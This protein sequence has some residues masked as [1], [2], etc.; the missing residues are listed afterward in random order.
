MKRASIVTM[1]MAA[2][3]TAGEAA[4]APKPGAAAKPP[5][6]RTGNALATQR[7]AKAAISGPQRW[8]LK[9]TENF[10]GAALNK[11]L[12]K[13]I[14]GTPDSGADWQRNISPRED[15]ATVKRGILTL[16]GIKNE[17]QASDPRRMLAGGIST[18]GLF[19]MKYGKIEARVR[20]KGCKGAWPAFWMMPERP[21]RTWPDCGEIDIFERLNRD[22]FVLQ[23]VH[24]GWAEAH[25]NDPPR[26]GK[27]AIKT[28]DWNV[29]A[30]EWTPEK[31]VWLVNG[32]ATHSYPKKA[33]DPIRWPWDKP[34]Y[35][36]IDM[37]LGGSWVGPVN[38]AELPVTMEVD[39]IK[40]YQLVRGSK[41][42]SEMV[43]PR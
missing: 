13:R 23:T 8:V 9:Y 1:I 7:T 19:N 41:Q 11:K 24:S 32:K 22:N 33:D 12:W 3:L 27:G 20:L 21:E 40:F 25:P 42:V 15:L 14:V 10:D 16:H 18:Q 30:L 26:G 4:G 35:I 28:D 31:L 36:M 34:F 6:T 17:D 29:Y 43:R 5:R 2:L 37:Q 38:E 39:W